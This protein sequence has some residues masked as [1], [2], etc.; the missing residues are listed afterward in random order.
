[1]DKL[2]ISELAKKVNVNKKAYNYYIDKHRRLPYL[3]SNVFT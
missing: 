3:R 2:L 1:M